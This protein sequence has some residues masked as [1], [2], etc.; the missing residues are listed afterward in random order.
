MPDDSDEF[1]PAHLIDAYWK[2][3]YRAA[4]KTGLSVGEA[5]DVVKETVLS[6]CKNS[7]KF[8]RARG[9]LKAWILVMARWRIAEQFRRRKG[10]ES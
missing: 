3:I 4:R 10:P 8:D 9:S 5:Q 1:T 2:L 7:G 6:A